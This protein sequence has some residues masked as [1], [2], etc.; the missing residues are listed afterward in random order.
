MINQPS[1]KFKALSDLSERWKIPILDLGKLLAI[2]SGLNPRATGGLNNQYYGLIQWGKWER[3]N[4]LPELM[5]RIGINPKKDIR[6]VPF[7]QQVK[8]FELWIEKRAKERGIKI[9]YTDIHNVYRII[10][11]GAYSSKGDAF[12][13]KGPL[14][15]Q[16]QS[17]E[18]EAIAWLQRESGLSIAKLRE[19]G[20]P[21]V[22]VATSQVATSQKKSPPVSAPSTPAPNKT[23]PIPNAPQA[24]SSNSAP[25][26]STP[27]KTLLIPNAPQ[28]I[29][30]TPVT[31]DS[32]QNFPFSISFPHNNSTETP[33]LTQELLA[34]DQESPLDQERATP[35]PSTDSSP[36]IDSSSSRT[37]DIPTEHPLKVID[38]LVELLKIIKELYENETKPK[39][40]EFQLSLKNE[41]LEEKDQ[42]QE[43]ETLE[44]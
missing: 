26:T 32:S 38:L 11:P 27:N 18:R 16:N 29:T 28:A 19:I 24:I 39:I 20:R 2:E 41:S 7:E 1:S 33:N 35:S 43:P 4:E 42:L 12:G 3:E 15:F 31:K 22:N 13:T 30:N 17:K 21:S 36:S 37:L 9:A 5:K 10:N 14:V 44:M 23:L 6:D 25:F 8:L 40:Q 34:R